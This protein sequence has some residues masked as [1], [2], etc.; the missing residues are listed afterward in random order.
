MTVDPDG[1]DDIP[2]TESKQAQRPDQAVL[3]PLLKEPVVGF[4]GKD[5]PKVVIYLVKVT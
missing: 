1:P 2:E 4:Y 5:I 3:H